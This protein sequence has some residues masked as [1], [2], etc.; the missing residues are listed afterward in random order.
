MHLATTPL[1]SSFGSYK[2]AKLLAKHSRLLDPLEM[3]LTKLS[4]ISANP[5]KRKINLTAKTVMSDAMVGN[6]FKI[7]LPAIQF[8]ANFT[9]E[10]GVSRLG[11]A[12]VII[13]K[14]DKL[15]LS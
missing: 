4:R 5:R 7:K 9:T 11:K 6:D 12:Y 3:R 10:G 13:Q 14:S 2:K 15:K 1:P 8:V